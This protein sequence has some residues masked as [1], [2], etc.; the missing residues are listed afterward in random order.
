M[1]RAVEGDPVAITARGQGRTVAVAFAIAGRLA[2][3]AIFQEGIG[4][5]EMI[6]GLGVVRVFAPVGDQR[7]GLLG[8]GVHP[9]GGRA[10]AH[11]SGEDG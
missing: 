6:N 9:R 2:A 11:C 10:H 5:A 8:E 7:I 4:I 1:P 3:R